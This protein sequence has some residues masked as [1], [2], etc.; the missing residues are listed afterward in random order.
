LFGWV[1]RR[2]DYESKRPIDVYLRKNIDLRTISGK[3]KEDQNGRMCAS[4]RS[5]P[6]GLVNFD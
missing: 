3:E 4:A 6:R 2:D 1:A 5:F